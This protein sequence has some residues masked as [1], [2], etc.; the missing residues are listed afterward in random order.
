M[1]SAAFSLMPPNFKLAKDEIHI[2]CAALDKL[3]YRFKK[4]FQTLSL[5]ERIRAKRFYF[6]RDRKRFIIRRGILR[7]ILGF[8]LNVDP[9]R[10]EFRY[11]ENG[12]P[13]LADTYSKGTIRFNLS[14]SNGFV[15]FAFDRDNEIGVDIE[16][17]RDIYEMDHISQRFFSETE[18]AVFRTLPENKKKKA[19]FN[20]WTRKEAFI[21]AIGDGL[22]L[23]LDKFDVSLAPGEPSRLLRIEGYSKELSLRSIESFIPAPNY[24]AALAIKSHVFKLRCW[25]WTEQA[26][27]A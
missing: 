16:E 21:K 19:F 6:E 27:S 1:F 24:V 10:I 4:Y 26:F 23:P 3:V 15:I 12:K 11:G 18:D 5:E 13:A 22:S 9:S 8:Y 25:R 2:W 20:C 14:H 17:I 7:T